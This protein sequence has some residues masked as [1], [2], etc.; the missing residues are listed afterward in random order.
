MSITPQESCLEKSR[1]KTA[2][3]YHILFIY[4]YVHKNDKYLKQGKRLP[5]DADRNKVNGIK[6]GYTRDFS[7]ILKVFFQKRG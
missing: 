6:E 4:S 7:G 3:Q 1:K 5:S 2:K